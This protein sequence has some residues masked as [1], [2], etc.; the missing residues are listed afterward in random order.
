KLAMKAPVPAPSAEPMPT[1]G[2]RGDRRTAYMADTGSRQQQV[3]AKVR[4]V[5]DGL[6]SNLGVTVNAPASQSSLQLALE[7]EKLKDAQ[8]AYLKVLLSEGEKA[9]DVVG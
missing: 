8:D 7:N 6:S 9:D 1:A 5:Q 4:K 3:W 2:I